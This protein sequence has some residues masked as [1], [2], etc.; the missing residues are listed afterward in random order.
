MAL[1]HDGLLH[2]VL[3]LLA[4]VFPGC[5]LAQRAFASNGNPSV[6][7]RTLEL[8]MKPNLDLPTFQVID[9]KYNL[10]HNLTV[11]FLPVAEQCSKVPCKVLYAYTT[12]CVVELKTENYGC[13]ADSWHLE[14]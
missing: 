12:C 9:K 1:R 8:I 14:L 7:Q 6:L 4:N 2:E 5:P 11:L 13:C 10:L 3:G